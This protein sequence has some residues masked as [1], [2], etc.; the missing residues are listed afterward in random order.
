MCVR[1]DQFS[2]LETHIED[3]FQA[4]NLFSSEKIKMVQAGFLYPVLSKDMTLSK[5]P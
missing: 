3:L 2:S 1:P 5:L 4:K